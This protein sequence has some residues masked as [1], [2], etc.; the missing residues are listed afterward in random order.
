MFQ[1]E[2]VM[3]RQKLHID[4][5]VLS[6]EETIIMSVFHLPHSSSTSSKSQTTLE[7]KSNSTVKSV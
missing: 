2:T 7:L 3:E 5:R 4:S 6:F 1:T